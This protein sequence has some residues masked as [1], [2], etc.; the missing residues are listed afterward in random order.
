ML[1]GSYICS[2]K[3]F[4]PKSENKKSVFVAL[5]D[6]IK[7]MSFQARKSLL[8]RTMTHPD[9]Q[10]PIA[11]ALWVRRKHTLYGM[12]VCVKEIKRLRLKSQ[13]YPCASSGCI[14]ADGS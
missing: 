4:F 13:N 5:P 14:D 8:S 3:D 10:L 1:N 12:S 7:E 2:T 9:E 11:G 6:K